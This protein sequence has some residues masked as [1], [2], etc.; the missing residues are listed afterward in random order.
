LTTFIQLGHH[1]DGA[2][3]EL[4]LAAISPLFITHPDK[5][6]W[7]VFIH[8]VA[9]SLKSQV[10]ICWILCLHQISAAPWMEAD[11]ASGKVD[12]YIIDDPGAGKLK[13][14]K[15]LV[16]TL[17]KACK[18]PPATK[19]GKSP[20]H[21]ICII[22]DIWELIQKSDGRDAQKIAWLMRNCRGSQLNIIAGS[23]AGHRTL[24]P[25]LLRWRSEPSTKTNK[26]LIHPSDVEP[27]GT[28]LIF[29]TEGLIFQSVP[30]GHR[31]K[32]WYAPS[33]WMSYSNSNSY[34]LS[35]QY[36]IPGTP[37]STTHPKD[38]L[39]NNAQVYLLEE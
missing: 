36:R 1:S 31:W 13:N 35:Q 6:H 4:N 20:P 33:E 10:D 39:P 27:V 37:I 9:A 11:P 25:D 32:K 3:A 2:A 18:Q 12:A 26:P 5:R 16:K 28:E 7:H 29:G 21:F 24:F 23:A 38:T 19:K 34:P 15:Q 22:D 17:M 30:G 8:A 14:R